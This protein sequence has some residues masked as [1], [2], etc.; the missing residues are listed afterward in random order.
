MSHYTMLSKYGNCTRLLKIKNKLKIGCFYK[1]W[2]NS[3]YFVGVFNKTI[4][5]LAL[6][7]YDMIIVSN[8]QYWDR[9][10]PTNNF[11]AHLTNIFHRYHFLSFNITA[12]LYQ[13]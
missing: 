6:V 1:V 4:I 5:P 11:S 13:D 8:L 12:I 10:L 9:K 7:G 2:R 3:R